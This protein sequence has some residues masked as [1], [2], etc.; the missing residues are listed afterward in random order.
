VKAYE[1]SWSERFDQL[2]DVLD[3]LQKEQRDAPTD[4]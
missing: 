4:P 3:D 2:D 1:R